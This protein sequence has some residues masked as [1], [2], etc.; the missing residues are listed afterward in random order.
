[1]RLT[2]FLLLIYTIVRSQESDTVL[3]R[4]LALH[5]DTEKVNQLYARGFSLRNSDPQTAFYYANL[6][7]E[8][9]Q[10][11]ESKIHLAK[12]YNLLGILFYKKGDYKTALAYHKKSLA[13]RT[14]CKNK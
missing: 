11:S 4:I 10:I 7:E 13:L 14:E 12:S 3:P 6:C 1:M 5:N 8:R 2:V 9:A